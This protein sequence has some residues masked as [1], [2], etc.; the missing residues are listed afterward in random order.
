M[1][2]AAIRPMK[3]PAVLGSAVIL[4]ATA[5]HGAGADTHLYWGDTHLH[6]AHS[7]DA[8]ATGNYLADPDVAFRYARGLPVLHPV[9]RQKIRID[10]PLDFL[11]VADHAEMLRLQISLDHDDPDVMATETGR[12]LAALEKE[13]K[14]AVFGEVAAINTGGGKD[15]LRDLYSDRVRANAWKQ[16]VAFADRNNIPGTVHGA[17]RLGMVGH[18]RLPEPAPGGVHVGGCGNRQPLPAIQFLRQFASRRPVGLA[19]DDQCA[20]PARSSLPSRT[21]RTCPTA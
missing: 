1:Q 11:V 10:R 9:T 7:V 14:R 8:Y 16:Q 3:I 6:T 19:A 12:R 21:T 18:A 20:Q 2:R 4:L 15:L 5:A 13:N 17:D